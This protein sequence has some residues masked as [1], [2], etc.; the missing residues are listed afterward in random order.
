MCFGL[1]LSGITDRDLFRQTAALLS[2]RLPRFQQRDFNFNVPELVCAFV[3][4]DVR[5]DDMMVAVAKRIPTVLNDLS[6]WGLCA[7]SW[8]YKQTYPV[9]ASGF[10]GVWKDRGTING[11]KL[12]REQG[13]TAHVHLIGP[14]RL[15]LLLHDAEYSSSLHDGGQ[16]L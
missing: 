7:L 10:D 16:T 4:V 13:R 11:T 6:A 15:A 9:N 3:R 8:S 12:V 14:H 5:H 1:A 2:E